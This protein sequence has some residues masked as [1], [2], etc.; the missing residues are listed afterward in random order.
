MQREKELNEDKQAKTR[1]EEECKQREAAAI[2]ELSENI[3]AYTG[4]KGLVV[5]QVVK[6]GTLLLSRHSDARTEHKLIITAAE[7]DGGSFLYTIGTPPNFKDWVD[8]TGADRPED[9]VLAG[10]IRWFKHP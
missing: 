5:D 10:L 4:T 9:D 7:Q 1:K 2:R 6:S 3:N 8:V